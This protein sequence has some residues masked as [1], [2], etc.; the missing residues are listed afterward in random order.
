VVGLFVAPATDGAR[1][2]GLSV[3]PA[4]EGAWL[5]G[6]MV[7]VGAWEEGAEVPLK[8]TNGGPLKRYK[9]K[10]SFRTVSTIGPIGNVHGEGGSGA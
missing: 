9:P 5:V 3:E 6:A 8:P 1:V 7:L 2:V 10:K 4:T